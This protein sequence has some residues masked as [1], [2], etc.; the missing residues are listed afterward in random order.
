MGNAYY[1]YALKDPR[2]GRPF[3]IGKGTGVRAWE[4]ALKI[5]NTRKGNRIKEI[6]AE[7]K[8]VVISILADNLTEIQAL[9]LESELISAFGTEDT[10]GIL[11]NKVVPSGQYSKNAKNIVIPYGIKEK[12]QLGLQLLKEAILELAKANPQGIQNSD[13]VKS[14]GLQ[15][16]YNGGS[17]DY[18]TWSILGILMREGKIKRLENSRKHIAQVK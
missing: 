5:D 11:T 4:H 6:V 17:K 1:V 15:S 7:G 16:D 18:L 3:Y 13:V 12:A 9:K 10:G 14:L 8:N 2:S